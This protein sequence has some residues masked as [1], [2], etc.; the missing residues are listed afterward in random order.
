MAMV[1]EGV[2]V[3]LAESTLDRALVGY[4]PDSSPTGRSQEERPDESDMGVSSNC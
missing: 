3:C 2:S 1:D 4:L